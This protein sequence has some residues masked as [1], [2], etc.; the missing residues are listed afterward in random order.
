MES[1]GPLRS[2]IERRK[3]YL[4]IAA[5]AQRLAERADSLTMRNDYLRLA[6]FWTTLANEVPLEHPRGD[7]FSRRAAPR[8]SNADRMMSKGHLP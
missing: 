3:T 4:G 1:L 5:D 6:R 7:R 8:A 2:E